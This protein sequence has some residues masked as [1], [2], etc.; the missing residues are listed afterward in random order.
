MRT[1]EQW[2]KWFEHREGKKKRSGKKAT[3]GRKTGVQNSAIPVSS[4]RLPGVIGEPSYFSESTKRS[5][6]LEFADRRRKNPTPAEKELR[7][8]LN[9]LNS[10]ILRGRFK[11]EYAISGKWI[12]DFW[13]PEIR[14]AIEVDG[15]VHLTEDQI[16]RDKL[17]DA[18]CARF[19]ITVLRITNR[20]IYGDRKALINKLRAGWR[21]ALNRENKIIGVAT[22]QHLVDRQKN[23]CKGK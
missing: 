19:D 1:E 20:E 22:D 5:K 15:S 6:V 21:E 8:I 4:L 3:T 13:I 23:G 14:L 12:V 11:R 17:K 18:D 10:G 16:K 2:R 9:Q 7:R